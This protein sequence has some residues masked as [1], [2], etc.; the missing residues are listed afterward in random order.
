MSNKKKIIISIAV[1]A[2]ILAG[3]I[4]SVFAGMKLNAAS[5]EPLYGTAG[6]LS[7]E[8][9]RE[10]TADENAPEG[11]VLVKKN[12]SIALYMSEADCSLAVRDI[13]TG[14]TWYSTPQ[15]YE[16]DSIALGDVKKRIRS[17]L[18]LK[19]YTEKSQVRYMDSYTYSIESEQFEITPI[20]DGVRVT[21]TVGKNTVS[22]E[23]LPTVISK[24]RYEEII[25]PKLLENEEAKKIIDSRYT[26][27]QVDTLDANR[28]KVYKGFYP[29]IDTSKELLILNTNCPIYAYSDIYEVFTEV[30]GYTQ[31]DIQTDNAENGIDVE[32]ADLERFIIPVEYTIDGGDF[33]A[34]IVTGKIEEPET[35]TLTGIN[36]LEFFG[37]GGTD[38]E[39]Y[40]FVPDG[41]GAIVNFNNGKI[42][43]PS[44]NLSVY[45]EDTSFT[46][47]EGT[48]YEPASTLIPVFG[49]NRNNK[50]FIAIIEEGETHAS[51]CADISEKTHSYNQVYA[52]FNIRPYDVMTVSTNNGLR[53]NN[54]YQGAR[55]QTDCKLR[56]VFVDGED[57]SYVGMANAYKQYL[58]ENGDLVKKDT[59][60]IPFIVELL[61]QVESKKYYAGI[62]FTVEDSVTSFDSANRAKALGITIM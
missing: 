40:M 24:K 16:S 32:V 51:I 3:L 45:G 37:A 14:E 60:T 11:M 1:I 25:L 52:T 38:D 33:C 28:Q 2:V 29:N 27:I 62:P 57:M 20:E 10:F 7:P 39:G 59:S 15:D 31:E 18:Y 21:Y 34:R 53:Y 6:E 35:Y 5:K 17:Q 48:D 8:V 23:M 19:Y 54:K 26:L 50:S 13:S 55:A 49:I 41:S 56:Y 9:K 47:K 22:K 12:D 4:I 61:G 46:R 58:I 30:V 42:D 36:L 43:A 44:Y